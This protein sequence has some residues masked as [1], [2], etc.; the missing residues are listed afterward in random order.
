MTNEAEVG[1]RLRHL[2][3]SAGLSQRELAKK[4]MV[5]TAAVTN[6][7]TGVRMPRDEIKIRIANF[8]DKTVQEIFFD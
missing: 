6:Y 2:R 5:S 7:E 3:K 1:F 4:I 8:F